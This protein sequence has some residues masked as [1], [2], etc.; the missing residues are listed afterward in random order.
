MPWWD[1]WTSRKKD[2]VVN[3]PSTFKVAIDE[4]LNR[5]REAVD[6]VVNSEHSDVSSSLSSWD[7]YKQPQTIVA[8]V[9]LTT[10]LLS[11]SRFYKTY[12][13]RIPEAT[14]IKPGFFRKRSIFGKVT[15][16][17][18]GDNFR[19]YHTPGGLLSGWHWLPWRT[20][21]KDKKELRGQTVS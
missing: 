20:V 2:D 3:N 8:T 18:D 4:K 12:L 6:E 5:V 9:I 21:P 15:S 13:R 11:S 19:L 17:G 14:D 16:V 10:L 1:L 7:A